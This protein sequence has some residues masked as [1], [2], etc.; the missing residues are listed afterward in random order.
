MQRHQ[1]E[2]PGAGTVLEREGAQLSI[3]VGDR[4]EAQQR[5]DHDVA[6]E[7]NLRRV[8]TLAQQVLVAVARRREEPAR[9]AIGD[10]PVDL[11]PSIVFCPTD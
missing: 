9:Q 2:R 8:D 5:V 4:Q 7:M 3:A 6:N 11:H 1:H 10:E